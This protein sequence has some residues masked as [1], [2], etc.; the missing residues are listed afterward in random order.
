MNCRKILT[1]LKVLSSHKCGP[2]IF[3][4][5]IHIPNPC[6][7]YYR[8]YGFKLVFSWREMILMTVLFA[9]AA[10]LTNHI[11]F[12]GQNAKLIKSIGQY[13]IRNEKSV[14][15]R[16]NWRKQKQKT[17]GITRTNI[18]RQRHMTEINTKDQ[19]NTLRRRLQT[20]TETPTSQ[21]S[22]QPSGQPSRQP[23][24]QPSSSVPSAQPFG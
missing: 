8:I 4:S 21:P 10:T 20:S 23:S 6:A 18:V 15:R 24:S 22:G 14:L 13:S 12:A 11:A 17:E 2:W 1:G 3:S 16:A 7:S 9:L 5:R 19:Q